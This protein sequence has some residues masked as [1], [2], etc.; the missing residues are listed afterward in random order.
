MY[1]RLASLVLYFTCSEWIRKPM[2]QHFIRVYRLANCKIL[3]HGTT[4]ATVATDIPRC[5]AIPECI[6]IE[7]TLYGG[8]YDI[9]PIQP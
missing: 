1:G 4:I 5:N 3:L 8:E 2:S 6:T 9:L 7:M